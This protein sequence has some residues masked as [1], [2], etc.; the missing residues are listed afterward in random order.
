MTAEDL[1]RRGSERRSARHLAL[2]CVDNDRFWRL[3][4]FSPTLAHVG[5]GSRRES[6]IIGGEDI[7]PT[8]R[9]FRL[10]ARSTDH[11]APLLSLMDYEPSKIDG[12]ARERRAA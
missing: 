10:D 4:D 5:S 8:I 1:V 3:A 2:V 7:S 9:S 6:G 12:G 11:L